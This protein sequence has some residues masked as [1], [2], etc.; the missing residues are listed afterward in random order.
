MHAGIL[1][2]PDK[3]PHIR[4]LEKIEDTPTWVH[5]DTRNSTRSGIWIIKP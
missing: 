3:F 5:W 2:N 4:V 1:A